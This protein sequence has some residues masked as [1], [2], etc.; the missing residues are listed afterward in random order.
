[1]WACRDLRGLATF[2]YATQKLVATLPCFQRRHRYANQLVE[3]YRK[4]DHSADAASN[5]G[6]AET[7][8]LF[9]QKTQALLHQ[10]CLP[11]DCRHDC[12]SGIFLGKATNGW[13]GQFPCGA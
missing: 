8:Q 4:R 12:V 6:N 1:M 3:E 13:I 5:T 7:K 9:W 11:R 2:I 10:L